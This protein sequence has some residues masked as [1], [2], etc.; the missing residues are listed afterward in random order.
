MLGVVALGVLM[1]AVIVRG[2]RNEAARR[3]LQSA[4]NEIEVSLANAQWI[5][6]R[7]KLREAVAAAERLGQ[8]DEQTARYRQLLR[9]TTALSDLL[10]VPLTDIL[11]EADKI[12][13]PEL[14]QKWADLF[15]A[16]YRNRWAFIEG[17]AIP[18]PVPGE[19]PE[20]QETGEW[21]IELPLTVGRKLRRVEL[22]VR[23]SS[24]DKVCGTEPRDV[25]MAI[26][27]D[28]MEQS[29]DGKVWRV[30]AV[31]NETVL[32]SDRRTYEGVGYLPEESLAVA[33]RLDEQRK[34]LGLG[35][36]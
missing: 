4:S 11:E 20:I 10:S 33:Q 7:N 22:I 2:Q 24:L 32:W 34:A 27:V 35:G 9:E 6:A 21:L 19:P 5:E 30:F 17:R 28:R 16:R 15:Q 1:V 8:Q 23:S 31:P 18:R 36:E 12:D 26:P 13:D 3:L 25:I 29:P 14:P